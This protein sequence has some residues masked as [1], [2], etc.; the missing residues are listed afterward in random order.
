MYSASVSELNGCRRAYL[1]LPAMQHLF[2]DTH[3]AFIAADACKFIINQSS[4]VEILYFVL[5]AALSNVYGL[6]GLRRMPVVEILFFFANF[7][8]LYTMPVI[9]ACQRRLVQQ[10]TER[11]IR[12]CE[13]MDQGACRRGFA[14]GEPA[15]ETQRTLWI[16]DLG[17]WMDENFL[18]SLFA[19][20]GTVTS[21]KIIR[22][23]ATNISEGYGF[24]EFSSHEAA[25][26]VCQPDYRV[27]IN[28]HCSNSLKLRC[29]ALLRKG[30]LFDAAC[31]F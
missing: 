16:G 23:K 19:A 15:N 11:L 27:G 20:T 9:S 3:A 28:D 7:T 1:Y 5:L 2:W 10:C 17:Y 18:Y 12:A 4:S 26:Q 29:S 30:F 6:S 24:I 25:S 14:M 8:M 22:S 13:S 31:R 21:V